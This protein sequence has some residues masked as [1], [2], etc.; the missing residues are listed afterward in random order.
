MARLNDRVFFA[1]SAVAGGLVLLGCVL[2]TWTVGLDA[3]V[4]AGEEQRA[5]NFD[6]DLHAITYGEPGSLVFP[7]GGIALGALGIV[8]LARPHRWV[9]FAV[10]GVATVLSVQAIRTTDYLRGG[11]E[12]GVYTCEAERL[13]DCVGFLAPAVRDLR[14]E[15]LRKP[16][17]QEPE[18]LGSGER[19]YRSGGRSGWTLMGWTIAVFSFVA[20][21]RAA[22]AMTGRVGVA[23]AV[24]GVIGLVV[25]LYLFAKLLEAAG[26]G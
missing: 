15:I 16:I 26:E 10:A 14:A 12:P 8:G 2:P 6:R 5:Y 19:S 13:D 23:F 21:F 3:A 9:V 25:L 1:S 24:V 4:G 22:L 11:D 7:L 20:W 17:A 18:F